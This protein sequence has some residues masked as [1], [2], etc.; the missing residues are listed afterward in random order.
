MHCVPSNSPQ[1]GKNT[2]DTLQY[3]KKLFHIRVHKSAPKLRA[4][5]EAPK[6]SRM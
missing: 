3:Q 2:A 4:K 1:N 6:S 5:S